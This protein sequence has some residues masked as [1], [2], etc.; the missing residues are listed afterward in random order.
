M[1][2]LSGAYWLAK[3]TVTP[4]L[5]SSHRT[6][7]HFGCFFLFTEYKSLISFSINQPATT[8]AATIS[9][10]FTPVTSTHG[11]GFLFINNGEAAT[12]SF[13]SH[14]QQLTAS[15]SIFINNGKPTTIFFLF[16]H[17]QL[18]TSSSSTATG[19]IALLFSLHHQRLSLHRKLLSCIFS[20][21]VIAHDVIFPCVGL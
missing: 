16:H 8:K 15:S 9:P 14:H 3:C 11:H 7:S 21:H 10:V 1:L 19:D 2:Q 13:L 4:N 12:I 20:L 6:R 5:H 17:Q 18:T